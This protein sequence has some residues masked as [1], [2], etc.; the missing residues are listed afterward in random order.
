M[1]SISVMQGEWPRLS[2]C[3]PFIGLEDEKAGVLYGQSIAQR[4]YC[5]LQG[6]G[7]EDI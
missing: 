5:V 7:R 4:Q 3:G 2:L 1:G 6:E